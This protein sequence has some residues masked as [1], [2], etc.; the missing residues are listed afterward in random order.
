MWPDI[1]VLVATV[2]NEIGVDP[3]GELEMAIM[4]RNQVASRKI[5]VS[6]KRVRRHA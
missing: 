5:A 6:G 1:A 3:V 4:D 2:D